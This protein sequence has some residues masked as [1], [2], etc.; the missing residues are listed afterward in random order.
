MLGRVA[1]NHIGSPGATV[2]AAKV[3]PAMAAGEREIEHAS[4]LLRSGNL[5]AFPTETVYGL[6]ADAT[7]D[8]AV[9]AVFEAKGRP[10]FNPLISH[11]VSLGHAQ[12][13]GRFN[14][15]AR[16]LAKAFWPGPLTLV[17]PRTADCAVSMLACAGL[18]T[19]ALRVP[20]HPV[21]NKLLRRVGRPLVGPSAN[22]SGKLSPTLAC[23]VRADLD[24]R[25]A[26]VLDGG[27]CPVGVEF[28]R[29]RMHR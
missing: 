13:L 2:R 15:D 19:I 18:A 23:H 28:D 3:G 22:T 11:V 29:S 16:A 17:V 7:N 20:A 5:V 10:T 1:L 21:A 4:E 12:Q 26:A 27:P 9:A 24:N 6:G 25:V 14:R 8:R